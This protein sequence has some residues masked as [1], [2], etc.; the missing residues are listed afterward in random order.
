MKPS[1]YVVTVAGNRAL[2][3]EG[4]FYPL[5]T[6]NQLAILEQVSAGWDEPLMPY[7]RPDLDKLLRAQLIEK[8]VE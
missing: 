7:D 3:D 4:Q 2:A 8:R 6:E 1:Q 5:L